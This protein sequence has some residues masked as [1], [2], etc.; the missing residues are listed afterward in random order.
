[1]GIE[2]GLRYTNALDS[3][4]KER[5]KMWELQ[6]HKSFRPALCG[7]DVK[8]VEEEDEAI[9]DRM[10]RLHTVMLIPDTMIISSSGMQ[11]LV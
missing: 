7:L 10:V 6:V 8:D 5:A 3:K 4:D 9:R 11:V 1:M 2:D